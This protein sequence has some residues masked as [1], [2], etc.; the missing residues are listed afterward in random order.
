[1]FHV[2]SRL[3][4]H[5]KACG[6]ATDRFISHFGDL[7]IEIQTTITIWLLIIAME[8]PL[9]ME[10][11]MGKSSVNGPFSIAMLNNQRV[12]HFDCLNWVPLTTRSIAWHFHNIS[13][14][15]MFMIFSRNWSFIITKTFQ[16][17][18]SSKPTSIWNIHQIDVDT[19]YMESIENR[20][21]LYGI[22]VQVTMYDQNF[23]GKTMHFYSLWHH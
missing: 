22:T 2:I 5:Q 17:V 4:S 12:H 23:L 10:V 21:D 6:E 18:A 14:T 8:N 15:G 19:I 9:K 1:M 7:T 20:Y 16:L 11:L 13:Y 3:P